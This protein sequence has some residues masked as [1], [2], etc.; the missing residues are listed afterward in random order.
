MTAVS[1]LIVDDED[2]LRD[3]VVRYLGAQGYQT[4]ATAT[5]E[6][7]LPHLDRRDLGLIITDFKMPGMNGL[8]VAR[9]AL[10]ANPDRPVILMSASV[11]VENLC[12]LVSSG[13]SDFI[14]KP[15]YLEDLGFAVRRA[16]SRRHLLTQSQ[17]PT[18]TANELS[19][20]P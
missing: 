6:E 7:A 3:L 13:I 8:E 18:Q 14:L 20:I 16:L 19:F 10:T 11:D 5:G 2:Q 17:V 15:F 9:R 4:V 1:I 12:Q